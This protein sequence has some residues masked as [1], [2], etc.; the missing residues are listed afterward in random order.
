[1]RELSSE[2]VIFFKASEVPSESSLSRVMSFSSTVV[3]ADHRALAWGV[4]RDQDDE[5][6]GCYVW[7]DGQGYHTA[8]LLSFWPDEP[9]APHDFCNYLPLLLLS[10]LS[11]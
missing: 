10:F 1:M 8:S 2:R 5:G 11:L 9:E 4:S 6:E 7:Q 3:R